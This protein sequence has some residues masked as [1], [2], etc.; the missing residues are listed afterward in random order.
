MFRGR[1]V[2]LDMPDEIPDGVWEDALKRSRHQSTAQTSGALSLTRLTSKRGRIWYDED[3][4]QQ[5][6]IPAWKFEGLVEEAA[7]LLS[8]RDSRGD[9]NWSVFCWPTPEIDWTSTWL[10]LERE[11]RV[12]AHGRA[13]LEDALLS[14]LAK[15]SKEKVSKERKELYWGEKKHGTAQKAGG[16]KRKVPIGD[17]SDALL[18]I[19]QQSSGAPSWIYGLSHSHPMPS[20]HHSGS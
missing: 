13:G 1:E 16:G 15:G 10:E 14:I 8:E 17:R 2:L 4:L 5:A 9:S 19:S 11:G 6:C 7:L 18:D 12:V 20:G 3:Q